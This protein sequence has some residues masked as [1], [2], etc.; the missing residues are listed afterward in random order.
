[1]KNIAIINGPNLNLLGKRETDI[2]GLTPFDSFFETLVKK[3]EGR[4]SLQQ[5]QSNIEGALIDKLQMW[6]NKEMDGIILN[7]GA[8]SHTSIAIADAVKAINTPVINVHLSNIYQREAER[9]TDLIRG[10]CLGNI[11]GFGLDSYELA[12]LFFLK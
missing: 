4:V 10:A 1:M 8:Y 6:G 3:Y 12:L 5:F 11:S 9:H 7:A 2:Y